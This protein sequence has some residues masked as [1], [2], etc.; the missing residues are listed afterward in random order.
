M[1]KLQ[2]MKGSNRDALRKNWMYSPDPGFAHGQN[3]PYQTG[4]A[5]PHKLRKNAMG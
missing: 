4:K 3:V 1:A 5:D 2:L